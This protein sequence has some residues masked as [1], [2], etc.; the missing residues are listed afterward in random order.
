MVQ[1]CLP[2]CL[3]ACPTNGLLHLPALARNL[4]SGIMYPQSGIVYPQSAIVAPQ[5]REHAP[6]IF[7]KS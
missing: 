1:S 2:A 3:P 4:Q 6:E 7:E 5:A